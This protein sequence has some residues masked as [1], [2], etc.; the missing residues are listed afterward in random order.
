MKRLHQEEELGKFT[1]AEVL[2]VTVEINGGIGLIRITDNEDG[3]A[4]SEGKEGAFL[5]HVIILKDSQ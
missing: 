5:R 2:S 3:I 4:S 1:D